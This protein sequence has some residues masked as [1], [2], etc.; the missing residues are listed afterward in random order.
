M[1]LENFLVGTVTDK[2]TFTYT[3]CDILKFR[4]ENTPDKVAFIFLKDGETDKETITY[5]QL[6]EQAWA[7]THAI[8]SRGM[9]PGERALLLFPPG[10]EFVKTLFGCFYA[11]IYGV[12]AYPPRKNRSF[13]RIISIVEDCN[14]KLCLTVR[15]IR[16][17]FE[18]NFGDVEELR[19]LH[20]ISVDQEMFISK[21]FS[22]ETKPDDLALLQYTSGSTASPKGVMVSHGNFM[23]NLEFLRQC[24]EFTA[25]TPTVHWLPV[26]HDMGL[27]VGIIQPIYSG[28]TGILMSPVSFIQKPV[29][30][31]RAFSDYGGVM[32]SAPNFAYDHCVS[33]ISEEDCRDL[34]LETIRSVMNAAEPVR[35]VTIEQFSEKFKVYG[36]RAESFYPAYGLAEA[37]LIVSGGTVKDSPKYVYVN[38]QALEEGRIEIT[39]KD[40]PDSSYQVSVG[41][42]WI[43]T[44]IF[45]IDPETHTHCRTNEVGE[46]WVS[47]SI[48]TRGYWNKPK[49]TK[50]T[51]QAM[52]RDT[53]EG[54]FL[55]TG[56]LGFIHEGELYVTGRLKDLIILRGRN[57]YPQDI[58]YIAENSHP[59]LR[60]NASAA[61][62]VDL[63][64]EE[65]LV[66]VAEVERTAI[67]NLDVTEVCDAIRQQVSEEIEQ[68]V[69]AIQLLRTA[70][71]LKTSS[72]KIQRR[73]CRAAFLSRSLETVGESVLTES[74]LTSEKNVLSMDLVSIQAWL[75]AWIHVQ[76]KVPIEK[77]D[78]GKPLSAYGLNS[79]KA[80]HLQNAFL[81]KYGINF[82]PYLFFEKITIRELAERAG[83]LGP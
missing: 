40:D 24:F 50:A 31:L 58:E 2:D 23:R 79:M 77:I 82:P 17:S 12:P 76:L 33:K 69:Y 25:E 74:S 37:T 53:G 42:P 1:G 19:S 7:V 59:A 68:E 65:K 36:F 55:R 81:Q 61:F 51:F 73:A 47:G 26:F 43:D 49:E 52:I 57:Y 83:R 11:G 71:I 20:W 27:V 13:N 21:N 75:T 62:S 48:V 5:Q 45:I 38:K 56:D 35:K 16:D 3:I 29:R 78:A 9:Q 70:S 80:V 18:K 28:F 66:I 46:I 60:P 6:Y 54:P 41:K 4:A 64:G 72:G 8:R 10:M 63:D 67:R 14:P 39:T 34:H 15:D 30:W 44:N 22:Y 32:G